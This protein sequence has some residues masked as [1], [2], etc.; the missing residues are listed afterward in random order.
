M[1]LN[2]D[3]YEQEKAA[4]LVKYTMFLQYILLLERACKK[5]FHYAHIFFLFE[6][7]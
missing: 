2:G 4:N 3:E 7:S 1:I 5:M 6:G